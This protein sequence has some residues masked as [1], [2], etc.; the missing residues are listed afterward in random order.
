MCAYIQRRQ[1]QCVRSDGQ[2]DPAALLLATPSHPDGPDPKELSRQISRRLKRITGKSS[3]REHSLRHAFASLFL[4]RW[5]VAC[6][7]FPLPDWIAPHLQDPFFG[8]AASAQFRRL[9][10]LLEEDLP[11]EK[12]PTTFPLAIL[13]MLFGHSGPEGLVE[14]YVHTMDWLQRLYLAHP[15]SARPEPEFGLAEIQRAFHVSDTTARSYF[16]GVGRKRTIP[17]RDVVAKQVEELTKASQP[18]V[19]TGHSQGRK[20]SR[21]MKRRAP[22][23]RP[24]R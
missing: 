12:S 16:P 7:G 6:Y 2:V 23:G 21:R 1:R 13:T 19:S 3:L 22:A 8:E 14:T 9:V 11:T 24:G 10:G 18:K 5:Y 15:L 4:L 17:C 20:P